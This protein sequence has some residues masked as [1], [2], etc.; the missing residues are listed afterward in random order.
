MV[1]VVS[2]QVLLRYAFNSSIG[3]ADEISRL[4]FVWSIF[5]A[6]PLGIKLGVH[7]GIEMLTARL[8]EGIRDALARAVALTGAAL[9]SLVSYQAAI[10]TWDQWDEQLAS[11]DA[12]AA[13]FILALAV[14]CAHSALHL[15]WIVL[16]GWRRSEVA[17]AVAVATELV[18]SSSWYSSPPRCS[19]CRSPSRSV[20]ARSP[21]SS[22]ATSISTCS[23]R[24]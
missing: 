18:W 10:V 5:L 21:G 7:I 11:M 14:G 16:N 23:L 4:M 1:A 13:L 12:S 15:A 17:A 20:Q 24:G 3:W 6:I 8:P 19:A 22:R 2:A 9:M